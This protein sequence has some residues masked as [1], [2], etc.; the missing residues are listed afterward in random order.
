M[1]EVLCQIVVIAYG[2]WQLGRITPVD[3]LNNLSKSRTLIIRNWYGK[4]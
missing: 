3:V 2:S 4:K 1:V